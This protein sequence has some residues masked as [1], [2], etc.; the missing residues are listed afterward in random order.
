MNENDHGL[1]RLGVREADHFDK[2][3]FNRME[4]IRDFVKHK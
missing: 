4:M 1:L 3:A 2:Y